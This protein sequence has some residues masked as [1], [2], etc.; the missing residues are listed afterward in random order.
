MEGGSAAPCMRLTF[1]CYA[2]LTRSIRDVK[3]EGIYPGVNT[4]YWYSVMKGTVTYS[5]VKGS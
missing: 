4:L 2:C 3:I 5:K 1:P